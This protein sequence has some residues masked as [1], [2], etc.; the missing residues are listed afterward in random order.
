MLREFEVEDGSKMQL[1]T[2]PRSQAMMNALSII[3]NPQPQLKVKGN[4]LTDF[5]RTTVSKF[6]QPLNG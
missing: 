6:L 5:G 3:G 2:T 1:E 4:K